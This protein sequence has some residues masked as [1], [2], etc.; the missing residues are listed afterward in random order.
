MIDKYGNKIGEAKESQDPGFMLSEIKFFM[1]GFRKEADDKKAWMIAKCIKA[2]LEEKGSVESI[3]ACLSEL[4][5][6][7]PVSESDDFGWE[8]VYVRRLVASYYE[9]EKKDSVRS[10]DNRLLAAKHFERI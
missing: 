4:E 9:K 3:A 2:Y 5:D 10:G 8:L 6:Y 7:L 1:K